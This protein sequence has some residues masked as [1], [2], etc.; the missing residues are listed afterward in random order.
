MVIY[1][2]GSIST[3]TGNVL[4]SCYR[5]ASSWW[6]EA[7]QDRTALAY[8]ADLAIVS[9]FQPLVLRRVRSCDSEPMQQ[10]Q[11]V[12]DFIG[13]RSLFWFN[14]MVVI[15]IIHKDCDWLDTKIVT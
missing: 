3:S 11:P 12:L 6:N 14:G 5:A 4:K 15:I 2:I 10:Q 8:G 7:Q 9:I 1:A 13:F